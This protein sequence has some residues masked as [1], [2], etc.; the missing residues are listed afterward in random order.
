M[1]NTKKAVIALLLLAGM[2][3]EVQAANMK[4]LNRYGDKEVWITTYREG[5]QI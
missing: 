2:C 3:L 5:R 1:N 4:I